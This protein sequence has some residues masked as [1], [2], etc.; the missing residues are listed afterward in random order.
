MD[1]MQIEELI[2]K[3]P[4][5]PAVSRGDVRDWVVSEKRHGTRRRTLVSVAM[6][7]GFVVALGGLL[8]MMNA[9]VDQIR[10]IVDRQPPRTVKQL[11]EITWELCRESS[12]EYF[13]RQLTPRGARG[14]FSSLPS[15]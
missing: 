6:L 11:D 8:G 14:R 3:A 1:P 12:A 5:P 7:F 10:L 9:Q 15:F 4:A 13:V 2:L